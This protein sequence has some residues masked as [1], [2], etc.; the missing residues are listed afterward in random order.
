[1]PAGAQAGLAADKLLRVGVGQH[2]EAP[3]G[4]GCLTCLKPQKSWLSTL[5]TL[6]TQTGPVGVQLN[7]RLKN[8]E[9][10]VLAETKAFSAAV[11]V[12]PEQLGTRL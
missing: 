6:D 5:G 8:C 11:E 7:G 4:P 9:P 1:M 10:A 12:S 3:C 2:G